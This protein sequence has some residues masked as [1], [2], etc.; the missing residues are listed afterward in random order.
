MRVR[1]DP[2]I[3]VGD[4]FTLADFD[5]VEDDAADLHIREAVTVYEP[6]S[7]LR[8]FGSVVEVDQDKRLV[9]VAVDWPTLLPEEAWA[10]WDARLAEIRVGA[11]ERLKQPLKVDD[12]DEFRARIATLRA[13]RET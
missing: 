10:E 8:G 2:N 1:I 9:T 4:G 3:R 12:L 11:A 13:A 6:E 5:D 7:G